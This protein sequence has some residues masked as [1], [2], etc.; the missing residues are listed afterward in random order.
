VTP[1]DESSLRETDLLLLTTVLRWRTARSATK[2]GIPGGYTELEE[3]LFEGPLREQFTGAVQ[4]LC[5]VRDRAQERIGGH[6]SRDRPASDDGVPAKRWGG[7]PG[8]RLPGH[9]RVAAFQE[10]HPL[11]AAFL[12][13]AEHAWPGGPGLLAVIGVGGTETLV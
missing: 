13:Y 3:K 2:K 6:V 1:F 9:P 8:L 10:A 5:P 4:E 7:V 12:L 11:T